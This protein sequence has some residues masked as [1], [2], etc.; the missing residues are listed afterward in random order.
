MSPGYPQVDRLSKPTPPLPPDAVPRRVSEEVV[1]LRPPPT[2]A[3]VPVPPSPARYVRDPSLPRGCGGPQLFVRVFADRDLYR[4]VTVPVTASMADVLRI[5]AP[6]FELT[7]DLDRY[8]L[9]LA[10]DVTLPEGERPLLETAA[11]EASILT[12]EPSGK[13]LYLGDRDGRLLRVDQSPVRSTAPASAAPPPA[14]PAAVP[15]PAAATKA[16][17]VASGDKA[18]PPPKRSLFSF[19]KG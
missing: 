7:G 5:V 2:N 10:D 3:L 15:A 13:R 14:A 4:T 8:V 18:A 9:Y 1:V 6:K 11:P 16:S 19:R 17:A 12:V